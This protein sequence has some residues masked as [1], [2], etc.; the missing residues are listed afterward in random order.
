LLERRPDLLVA[1]AEM[2][3][4][5]ATVGVA[6]ANFFPTFTLSGLFGQ[7]SPELSAF[8]SGSANAWS[9][10][11]GLTGPIFEGG[12]LTAQLEQAKAVWEETKLFYERTALNSLREVSDALV[13]RQKLVDVAADQRDAVK[14][15]RTAVDV[16]QLRYINGKSSYYEV[17]AVQQELFPAEL[18]LAQTTLN[19]LLAIVD[20]YKALGGGWNIEDA[21]W[22]PGGAAA[23]PLTAPTAPASA[24]VASTGPE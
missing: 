14:S 18:S 7:V 21:G 20:L 8:T 15:Y 4:A 16:A 3:A 2:K 11:A 9:I 24:P 1:E 5:N 22:I 13:A 12:R 6:T 19:R 10:A 17:L 23:G